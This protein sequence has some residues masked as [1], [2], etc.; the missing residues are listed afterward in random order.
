MFMS[1][2]LSLT[3]SLDPDLH[4]HNRLILP[5]VIPGDSARE[6]L[7]DLLDLSGLEVHKFGNFFPLFLLR[8]ASSYKIGKSKRVL[9]VSS[10]LIFEKLQ[11]SSSQNNINF[12]VGALK[13][14]TIYA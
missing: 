6:G 10:A 8:A 13:C 2:T 3:C 1:L 14:F 7:V 4:V 5:L 12:V 9:K 11:F